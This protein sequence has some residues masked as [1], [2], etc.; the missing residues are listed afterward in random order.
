VR[1]LSEQLG[2]LLDDEPLVAR[3]RERARRRAE[4][5]AWEAVTDQYEQ[6]LTAVYDAHRPGPLPATLVDAGPAIAG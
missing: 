3:Y 2:R 5:Y 4:R 1:S 6:L